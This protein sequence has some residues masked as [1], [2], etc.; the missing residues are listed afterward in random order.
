MTN[1]K[2]KKCG[3]I[4]SK[5]FTTKNGIESAT[6]LFLCESC[7]TLYKTKTTIELEEVKNVE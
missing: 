2:C 7:L 5:V 1:L 4:L 6:D 3:E